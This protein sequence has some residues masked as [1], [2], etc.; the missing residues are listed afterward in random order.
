M[1]FVTKRLFCVIVLQ[2]CRLLFVKK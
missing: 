2:S 1:S